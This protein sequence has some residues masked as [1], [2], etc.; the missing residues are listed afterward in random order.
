[1]LKQTA[2]TCGRPPC[3]AAWRK[4]LGI[5]NLAKL[6]RARARLPPTNGPEWRCEVCGIDRATA[7]RRRRERGIP[8]FRFDARACSTECAHAWQ[9]R[10]PPEV[11]RTRRRFVDRRAPEEA[12]APPPWCSECGRS[13]VRESAERVRAGLPRL[14]TRAKTCGRPACRWGRHKRFARYLW[15]KRPRF[16]REPPDPERW[17]CSECGIDADTADRKRARAGLPRIRRR[18]AVT[19]GA[20]CGRAREL[21]R[22]IVRV[23][24]PPSRTRKHG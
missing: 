5:R 10:R 19:C 3:A 4:E 12:S 7:Q 14:G 8:G 23:G 20:E 17:R 15:A 6:D 2:K 16:V 1:M 21:R 22:Y 9:L 24:H 13:L 18:Y 11:D